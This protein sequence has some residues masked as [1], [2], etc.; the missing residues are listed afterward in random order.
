MTTVTLSANRGRP[1]VES[2]ATVSSA[3]SIV[4]PANVAI[5]AVMDL[6][7]VIE[8]AVLPATMMYDE[9][10]AYATSSARFPTNGKPSSW[11]AGAKHQRIGQRVTHTALHGERN[12]CRRQDPAGESPDEGEVVRQD[13]YTW[14]R[15]YD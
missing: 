12:Q 3:R 13:V 9:R 14:A 5:D 6:T 15:S 4:S 2:R 8:S 10:A 1:C 11:T 7:K